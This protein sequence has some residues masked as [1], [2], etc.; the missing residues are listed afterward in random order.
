M[1][2]ARRMVLALLALAVLAPGVLA[3]DPLA[4]AKA[5]GMVGERPDGLAGVVAASAPADIRA[6]VERVNR[7]RMQLYAQIAQRN[8]ASID[9]VRRTAGE[10]LVRDTAP[11]QYFMD[12]RGR[13]QRR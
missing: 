1:S 3:Q 12:E 9:A 5:S 10:R 8:G 7:E 13:W 2:G 4:A 11:G 6:L